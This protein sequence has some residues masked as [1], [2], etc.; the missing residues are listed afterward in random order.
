M[1]TILKDCRGYVHVYSEAGNSSSQGFYKISPEIPSEGGG[2]C[3]IQGIPLAYQEIVQ[4]TVTLD[5]LR[6]L[7]IF[8]SAWN[9]ISLSGMLLLGPND[10]GGA[11]AGA[12][13]AWYDTNRVSGS[14]EGKS[15]E[16]SIGPK[17]VQAYV[18][19]LRLEAANPEFN[20]QSF[21]IMMLTPEV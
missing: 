14:D 6:T 7:Y 21:S 8:G 17:S 16:L 2:Y 3:L 10:G 18:T 9:E 4:P 15:V 20:T 13:L 11:I 1:S 12:L 5:D 19:G